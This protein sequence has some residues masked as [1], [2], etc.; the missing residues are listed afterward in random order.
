ML[1][2]ATSR[3]ELF[4]A[5]WGSPPTSSGTAPDHEI[6][7]REA[8]RGNTRAFEQ[9]ASEYDQK[10][11]QLALRL[12]RSPEQASEIYQRVFAQAYANLHS[13]R[14]ECSFFVW[15]YRITAKVSLEHLEKTRRAS[16]PRKSN[17]NGSA[18]HSWEQLSACEALVLD[19]KHFEGLRLS[20]IAEILDSSEQRIR[21][22]LCR[23][24]Q[25]MRLGL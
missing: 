24:V 23:A 16:S 12:T 7:I 21:Q 2:R 20:T 15:I 22:V 5:P 9:L 25:K 10:L 19:L 18:L 11:L 1:N 4:G 14:F 6:L 13:F 3:Q 8:A 17:G